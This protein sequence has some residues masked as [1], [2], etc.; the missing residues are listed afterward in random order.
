MATIWEIAGHSVDH[1]FSLHFEYFVILVI[2]RFDFECWLLV[3]ITSVPGLC[4]HFTLITKFTVKDI[5]D[6]ELAQSKSEYRPQ[7]Q[8][9]KYLKSQNTRIKTMYGPSTALSQKKAAQL[10]EPNLGQKEI[11]V[12][13]RLHLKIG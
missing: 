3:L 13:S 9:R 7:N 10:P 11:Y 4:I 1:M 8:D 12:C 2:S 6:Q 5:N